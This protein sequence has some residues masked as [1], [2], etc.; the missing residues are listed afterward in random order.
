MEADWKDVAKHLLRNR[1]I[2]QIVDEVI[3]TIDEI[4]PELLFPAGKTVSV[5]SLYDAL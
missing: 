5:F 2:R 1:N 3:N 4:T